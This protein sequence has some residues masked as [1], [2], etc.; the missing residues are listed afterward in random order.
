M[1]INLPI[2]LLLIV[3]P[4][5]NIYADDSKTETATFA[6]GC[7]WCIQP[8]YDNATGVLKTSVGFSGGK[9]E[10]PDYKDVAYGRTSHTESIQVVYN[11]EVISYQEILDIFLKNHD[12][13][14]GGGQF[15]D[16]GKQYR[17]AIF[18]HNE[19][20]KELAEKALKELKDSKQVKTELVKYQAFYPA[21]DGHQKYYQ[22]N[23][24]RYKSYRYGCGRDKRLKEING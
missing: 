5:M 12:P 10:N 4:I 14:D 8:P 18:Y 1:I 19:K 2:V 21:D 17:P 20:Q 6:A 23:P 7:F 9:E 15:C 24:L 22:K 16:R 11:P 13:Y 3:A